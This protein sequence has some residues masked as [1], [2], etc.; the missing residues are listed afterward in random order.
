MG[1]REMSYRSREMLFNLPIQVAP[2][3]VLGEMTL[4]WDMKDKSTLLEETSKDKNQCARSP[5]SKQIRRFEGWKAAH[6]S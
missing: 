6:K 1:I 4:S 3:L 2:P 5:V